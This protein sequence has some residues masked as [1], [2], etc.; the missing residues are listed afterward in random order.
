[1]ESGGGGVFADRF[2]RGRGSAGA[3]KNSDALCT[4]RRVGRRQTLQTSSGVGAVFLCETGVVVVV[5]VV[6]ADALVAHAQEREEGGG[7]ERQNK[8]CRG[9]QG[10]PLDECLTAPLWWARRALIR[11]QKVKAEGLETLGLSDGGLGCGSSVVVGGVGRT[12]AGARR[13]V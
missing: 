3:E 13:I 8:V 2:Q 10:I 6:D 4:R 5:G 1:M 12:Q 11:R 7:G 9:N